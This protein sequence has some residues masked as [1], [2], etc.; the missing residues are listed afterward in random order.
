M[1]LIRND[2]FTIVIQDKIDEIQIN[3]FIDEDNI[4]T[5]II[6]DEN[7]FVSLEIDTT[8]QDMNDIF[9]NICVLENHILHYIRQ[10]FNMVDEYHIIQRFFND[11]LKSV[12]KNCLYFFGKS[13]VKDGKIKT[14]TEKY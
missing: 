2:K 7:D 8:R 13:F 12:E 1:E 5:L 4:L 11:F 6:K 9:N 10:D 14:Y 3:G